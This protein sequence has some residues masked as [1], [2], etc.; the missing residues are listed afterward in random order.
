MALI[1]KSFQDFGQGKI[2][3][4]I[5]SGASDTM[6]VSKGDFKEYKSTSPR[7][8]DSAKAIDGDFDIIGEGKVTKR[9]L[10]DGKEKE[11]TYTRAIHIP[12]LN[13]NL[14]SMSSFDRA[15]LMVTFGGGRG[16]VTKG[17]GGVVLTAQLVKGMYVVDELDDIPGTPQAHLG[18][19]SLSQPTPLEQWHRRLTH[20][21]PLTITE[22]SKGN[23]VDGLNI[24]GN[25]LH[26][27]CEDCIVGR[28]TR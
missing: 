9:Y 7:S 27:K 28:Q 2:P 5:D 6:F 1:S 23:L 16:V 26:G 13:A 24:S 20:C 18:V 8:G 15:G 21:S 10:V 4:F 17:D 11:V 19:A 12:S 25:D 22:M 3:T 14:I